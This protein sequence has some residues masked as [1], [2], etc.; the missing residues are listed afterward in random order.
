M[1][2][3]LCQ[4]WISAV[5]ID[6]VLFNNL[7]CVAVSDG[8]WE[9]NRLPVFRCWWPAALLLKYCAETELQKLTNLENCNEWVYDGGGGGRAA[10][11][12]K[13]LPSF[14]RNTCVNL[15]S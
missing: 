9:L 7:I 2:Q 4:G 11:I 3:C 15:N 5:I 6:K 10:L 1:D 13:D 12:F 8:Y 14:S